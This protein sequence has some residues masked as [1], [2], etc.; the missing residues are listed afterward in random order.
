V[1]KKMAVGLRDV[2]DTRSRTH[3]EGRILSYFGGISNSRNTSP[4]RRVLG[5]RNTSQCRPKEIKTK[6]SGLDENNKPLTQSW[7]ILPSKHYNQH[8]Q[9]IM[10]FK[11]I[12]ASDIYVD[13][14]PLPTELWDCMFVQINNIFH[15]QSVLVFEEPFL[16]TTIQKGLKPSV[17][18]GETWFREVTTFL[19][20]HDQSAE[21]PP[22]TLVKTNHSI[23][24]V[25]HEVGEIMLQYTIHACKVASLQ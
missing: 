17:R 10:S 3:N 21:V 8:T 22:T 23:F 16:H 2:S 19:L 1:V 25:N 24:N 9:L 7:R 15:F 11:V 12:E 13:N 14:K 20:D 4:I 6:L 18:V 5:F